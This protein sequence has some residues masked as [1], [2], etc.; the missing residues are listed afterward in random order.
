MFTDQTPSIA[1]A[2]PWATIKPIITI[3]PAPP[4][5]SVEPSR[6]PLHR[7]PR[8]SRPAYEQRLD[9]AAEHGRAV[10][11]DYDRNCWRCIVKGADGVLYDLAPLSSEIEANLICPEDIEIFTEEDLEQTAK[12]LNRLLPRRG[13]V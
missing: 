8:D 2:L 9:Y 13:A 12:R 1:M 7:Q 11:P 5:V 10:W 3:R 4:G 6:P